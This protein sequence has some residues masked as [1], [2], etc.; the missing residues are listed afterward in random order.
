MRRVID[1]DLLVLC[2]RLGVGVTFIYASF[3]KIIDPGA[4]AKSIWYYHLVPG[5]LINLIALILPW[6]ELLCGISLI[7]GVLYKGTVVLV[8]VLV[9]I[10]ILALSTTIIRGIDIGCGCFKAGMT[11]TESAWKALVFDL[12]MILF[13]LQ[14]LFSRS[15]RWMLASFKVT[16]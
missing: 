2:V 12:I 3:Y 13:T 15:K 10:F 6:V 14:L 1:N 8:N 11:A 16:S 5:D 7:L 9:V 4:F